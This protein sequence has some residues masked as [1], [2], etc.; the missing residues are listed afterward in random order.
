MLV[1]GLVLALGAR[2]VRAESPAEAEARERYQRGQKLAD[3][4][5]WAP[6]L[7]ELE[8]SYALSHYP[9]ILYRIAV[10]QEQLHRPA[11]ALATYR[12]YLEVEPKSERRPGVEARIRELESLAP[13]R[14][15]GENGRGANG[16][17]GANSA[18]GANGANSA[19]G[20]N[21]ANGA[22]VTVQTGSPRTPVYRRWWLWTT[23][24]LVAGGALAVGLGVGLT[25]RF[26]PDLG[27]F[28]P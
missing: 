18:N 19:N 26:N 2:S 22:H 15:S 23:V 9:A 20:A 4:A 3:Q 12:R 27:S 24:G 21:G 10:C 11:D 7:V 14:A 16:A 17:N 8:A 6:A 5:Q 13:A 25:Q 28:G 1:L